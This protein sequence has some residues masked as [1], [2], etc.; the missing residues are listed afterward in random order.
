MTHKLLDQMGMKREK[1]SKAKKLL[2]DHKSGFF[3]FVQKNNGLKTLGRDWIEGDEDE[4]YVFFQSGIDP[5][6]EKRMATTK[7]KWD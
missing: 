7:N 2:K 1:M 3:K 6:W 5:Q 4:L